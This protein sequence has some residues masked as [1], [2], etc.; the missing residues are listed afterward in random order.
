MAGSQDKRPGRKER[1]TTAAA[2]RAERLKAALRLN[3]K[4]RK[5]QSARPERNQKD[6]D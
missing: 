1:P 2:E 3:L 6:S 4:K 5:S